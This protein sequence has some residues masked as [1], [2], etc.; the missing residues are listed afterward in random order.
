[1][2]HTHH[3]HCIHTLAHCAACDVAYCTKCSRQWGSG[4]S[5]ILWGGSNTT[6][7]TTTTTNP[8]LG[9]G[10][11]ANQSSASPPSV[12]FDVTVPHSHS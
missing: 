11:P 6:L 1:M 7:T 10:Y 8:T 12:T 2:N 9:P 4:Y 5:N 3:G